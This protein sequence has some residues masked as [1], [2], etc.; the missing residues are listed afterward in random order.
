MDHFPEGCISKILSLTSPKDAARSSAV[1]HIFMSAAE[2]D[3]V[4]ETFVPSDYQQAISGSRSLMVFPS[5]KQ[6]YFS[7]CDSPILLDG[8]KLSLSLDKETGGKCLMVAARNLGI[9][10][11]GTP[12]YW[13]WLSHS[14]ARFSEVAKLK[15]ISWLD[16]RGKIGT[17]MLS[18]RTSYCA[19]LVFKLEDGFYGL[20]NVK[21]VVRFADTESDHEVKKRAKV[22]HFSEQGSRA[23]PPLIRSDGWMELKMGNFFNDTGEDGDVEARLMQIRQNW[24]HGLIVQGIEFRPE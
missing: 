4:W 16:I 17:R 20:I 18:K 15:R 19:Y 1:S 21:A 22:V 5:K 7:L 11:G 2:S 10:W 8:G 9:M 12:A 14:D 23:R 13:E 24:K 6:L 3:N